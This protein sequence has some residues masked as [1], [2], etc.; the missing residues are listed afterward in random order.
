MFFRTHALIAALRAV[1]ARSD[2]R[3]AAAQSRLAPALR[4]VADASALRL[5]LAGDRLERAARARS[6][7]AERHL[8]A[9]A[10]L[11]AVLSP[12][13]TVA[14]GYVIVRDPAD[15]RPLV[16]AADLRPGD[17]VE[18]EMRDGRVDATVKGVRG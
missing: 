1:G 12:S 13:R 9:S 15:A 6:A 14:R 8:A 11:L 2:S 7:T 4:R 18:L 10:A 5:P 16:S 3:V 17:M